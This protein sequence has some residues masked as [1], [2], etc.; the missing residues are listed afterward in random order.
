MLAT[1]TLRVLVAEGNSQIRA[2][3]RGALGADERFEVCAQAGDAAKAVA[4]AMRELP[5]LCVLDVSLPGG[6][7]P[8]AWEIGARLPRAKIVM[9]TD[10]T[11]DSDLFAALRA[12]A[13]GY[14]LKTMDFTKLPDTLNDVWAGQPAMDVAFVGLLFK[15]FRAR[16]PRWRRPVGQA[17]GRTLP[18]GHCPPAAHL[19]SR[20]WEVLQMLS[21]GLS[22]AEIS[23]SLTISASAVRVHVAAIV[24]KLGV[25]DR[26]AA[27]GVLRG[28]DQNPPANPC[29]SGN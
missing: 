28:L 2:E 10:S 24:R 15:H 18:S 9:L 26:D 6:G 20:E 21:E 4:A 19:T 3:L 1:R 8:A 23:R 13:E 16:E 12:G 5:D 17:S 14:L 7:L 11:R 22:T 29:R 27:V 25:A